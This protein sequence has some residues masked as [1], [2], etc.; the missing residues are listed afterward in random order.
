MICQAV[1]QV[2]SKTTGTLRRLKHGLWQASCCETS[3]LAA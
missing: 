2:K 3:R 1:H